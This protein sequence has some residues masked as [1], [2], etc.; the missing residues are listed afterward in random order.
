MLLEYTQV[1]IIEGFEKCSQMIADNF[2][3]KLWSSK[4]ADWL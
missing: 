1:E 2:E 4:A 3:I